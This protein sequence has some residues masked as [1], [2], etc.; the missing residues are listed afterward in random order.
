MKFVFAILVSVASLMAASP[1]HA[2]QGG[3]FGVGLVLGEPTALNFKYDATERN[4]YDL[5]LAFNFDKWVLVYADYQYK[6]AGAFSRERAINAITPYLGVGL[7]VVASNR[8]LDD[9]RHY[10]YFTDSASSKFALGL[11]VPLGLEWRPNAP[12]G[13][14]AELA[15]GVAVIPGTAAFL[16]GGLGIRYYF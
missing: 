5:G 13:I 4:A 8:S 9:T 15:P 1:A 10:Q 11:R 7:V 3:P 14:F 12:L 16:Q 6:F 2:D